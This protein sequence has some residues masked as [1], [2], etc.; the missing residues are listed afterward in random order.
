VQREAAACSKRRRNSSFRAEPAEAAAAAAATPPA[1]A[2]AA[3]SRQHGR[4]LGNQALPVV[5]LPGGIIRVDGL[6]RPAV[7]FMPVW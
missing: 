3:A 7:C 4:R 6:V 5:E 1:A 2:P